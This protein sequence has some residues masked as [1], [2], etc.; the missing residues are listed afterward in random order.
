ML[1]LSMY[2]SIAFVDALPLNT[3]FPLD[4]FTASSGY[5]SIKEVVLSNRCLH[6]GTNK[7]GSSK[8]RIVPLV[9]S[10][11]Q[12]TIPTPC[13]FT[14][15]SDI[16]V[17]VRFAG[18]ASYSPTMNSVRS[19]VILI[20]EP[21]SQITVLGDVS[22][23]VPL[24]LRNM[25]TEVWMMLRKVRG[26]LVMIAAMFEI[27]LSSWLK[28]STPPRITSTSRC[29]SSNA[30]CNRFSRSSGDSISLSNGVGLYN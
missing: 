10:N 20:D 9:S 5:R 27:Q 22:M 24:E 12:L 23:L 11:D 25:D 19:L 29:I 6:E 8:V 26:G 30:V 14:L 17:M 4:I 15:E 18:N 28:P 13:I 21:E 3:N 1:L 7:H 16:P 2:A